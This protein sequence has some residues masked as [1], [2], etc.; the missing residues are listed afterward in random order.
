M[1]GPVVLRIKLRYDDVETMV[2][3]FAP[4]VGKSGLF[5]PT[6]SLQPVGAEVKF[7]LRLSTEQTVLVGLG[8]VKVAKPPDP[9]DPK[10]TFGMSVELMRVTRES[11]DL[12]LKILERRRELGLPELSIPQPSDIDAARRA[13]AGIVEAVP[14]APPIDSK[15][16]SFTA[17]R[18][19][20]TGPQ[21]VAKV[22]AVAPLA[23]EP[24]RR[25]RPGLGELIERASGPVAMMAE[26]E[27]D[28][29][30]DVAA[31]LARARVLAGGD[32][33]AELDALRE[34]AAAPIEIS[35]E[36]ASAELARKLGWAP[37]PIVKS[38]PVQAKADPAP[39]P[40]EP[41]P[42]PEPEPEAPSP[43]LTIPDAVVPEPADT[44]ADD[45]AQPIELITEPSQR[46]EPE[47]EPEPVP[48][49]E[50]RESQPAIDVEPEQIHDEIHQLADEDFEEIE[51]TQ[52]GLEPEPEPEA[53]PAAFDEHAF[54]TRPSL[55]QEA[56]AARLDA[57]L[58]EAEA[59]AEDDDW[60][61][62]DSIPPQPPLEPEYQQDYIHRFDSQAEPQRT[63]DDAFAETYA[64]PLTDGTM[65]IEEIQDFEIL[66]EADAADADLLAA[67]GEQDAST[68]EPPPP[69]ERPSHSDFH[70]RL[71]LG[72]DSDFYPAIAPPSD[73]TP[74]KIDAHLA[75]SAGHALAALASFDDIDDQQEVDEALP[76]P[77]AQQ[78][79][80]PIYDDQGSSSYTFANPP[81]PNEFE[82]E[83]HNVADAFTPLPAF[84][85][86]DVHERVVDEPIPP[87]TRRPGSKDV[88]LESALEAL[89]VD[90]DDLSVPHARTE[91]AR[92]HAKPGRRPERPAA[93]APARSRTPE[94]TPARSGRQQPRAPRASTDD[95]VL[96]DFDDFED[97]DER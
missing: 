84:D 63:L 96:I 34:S 55:E 94:P 20:A 57:E 69:A 97:P 21:A 38:E 40:V 79:I 72:D 66:A 15:P 74:Q 30:V 82:D 33:D 27:L 45:E 2:Q 3:R 37:P 61:F 50:L 87:M 91:L 29:D 11:R 73:G 65:D 64:E 10:A 49:L 80:Q 51:Q 70:A 52:I 39:A 35:I 44:H 28:A 88:D 53:D 93:A 95:G 31:V 78:R 17:P 1:A 13:D 47:P 89:D 6:K 83:H 76:T 41:E 7:E 56:I 8:R 86:S 90:L 77:P 68:T 24:P 58:A 23:P 92:E 5:L 54:A 4:N 26:P 16:E 18:R 81:D 46:S 85:D 62:G 19:V 59:Q 22:A 42:E 43:A 75:Q 9:D 71:D 25:K 12:I 67:H 48:E 32:L 14:V 36:A 60:G